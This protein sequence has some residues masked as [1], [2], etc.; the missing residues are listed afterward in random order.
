M[1]T[2]DDES[3]M[4]TDTDTMMGTGVRALWQYLNRL[5]A[6]SRRGYPYGKHTP[7]DRVREVVEEGSTTAYTAE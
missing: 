3:M 6:T 5:E 1:G 4:I 7:K 2:V